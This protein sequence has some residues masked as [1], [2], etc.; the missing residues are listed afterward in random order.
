[1]DELTMTAAG[2]RGEGPEMPNSVG[3]RTTGSAATCIDAA[4]VE[5]ADPDVG[6]TTPA[7]TTTTP[8]MIRRTTSRILLGLVFDQ[9]TIHPEPSVSR[10]SSA[11]NARSD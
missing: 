6:D 5:A 2:V 3:Q 1:V 4:T 11:W 8:S 7:V 9:V 10:R